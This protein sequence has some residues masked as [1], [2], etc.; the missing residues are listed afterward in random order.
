MTDMDQIEKSNLSR[1]F[2]FRNTDINRPKSTTAIRAVTDM[3]AHFQGT[4]Y[5][6][7]V[8]LETE[9][10]FNDDFYESLDMVCTALDNVDARLYVDSK[11]LFYQKPMLE[12]GTLGAK[13]HTQIV[14]PGQTEHYGA[15][16]DPA[17]KSIPICTLKHFPNQIE[18]TL[19]WARDWFEEVCYNT[20]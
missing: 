19:Q 10:L 2:L 17:E 13:G 1:Q 14:S 18:H 9:H 3:N 7:K 6:Q 15:R 4:A 8:A 16:R 12:S 5:E 11:C 20:F